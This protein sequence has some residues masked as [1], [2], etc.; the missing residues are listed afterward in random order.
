MNDAGYRMLRV[1]AAFFCLMAFCFFSITC[2]IAKE[3]IEKPLK[4]GSDSVSVYSKRFNVVREA[5]PPGGVIGYISNKP[6]EFL[7]K[8][9]AEAAR[10]YMAQSFLAP[11]VIANDPDRGIILGNFSQLPEAGKFKGRRYKM[12]KNFGNGIFIFVNTEK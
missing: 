10:Y 7:E 11:V 5:L 4:I 12:V 8:D 9:N 1:K 3:V 2:L 6:P